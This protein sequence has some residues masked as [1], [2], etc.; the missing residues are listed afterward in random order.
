MK[1]QAQT[2]EMGEQLFAVVF[3]RVVSRTAKGKLKWERGYRAPRVAD[4]NSVDIAAALA[5]KLPEWE[6]LGIVP[7]EDIP[8]GAKTDEPLRYG[9]RKWS[10]LFSGRQL[11]GHGTAVEIYRA[12]VEE[13]RVAGL[14]SEIR[15]AAYV[16]LAF[17][18]DKMLNYNSRMSVWMSTRE[19]VA[20]TFNRHDFAFCWSHAEMAVLVDGLGFDW[21]VEQTSKCI[22]ELVDLCGGGVGPLFDDA[23]TPPLTVTCQSGDDLEHIAAAS[24]D[25]VIID[26][27]YGANVMY[28]ELSDFFYVWLKRT[29]GVVVPE[30]FTRYL[31]DKDAEAVAN[32]S[33]FAGEKGADKL[34]GRHYQDR[35]AAIFAEARRV[36]KA[37]GI[38]TVMFT[39]KDTGAWD[40]LTQGL[41]TAGFRITASWPVNTEAEGSLHIKD[42]AAANSTIFLVCRPRPA[43]ASDAEISY[44]EDVEPLVAK[45]V[46]DRVAEFQ[47]AGIKGVDLALASFGPALEKFSEHWPLRR[48]S[49]RPRPKATS[50]QLALFEDEFDPYAVSPEDA[51][52][53]ARR[54]VVKWRLDQITQLE[55]RADLDPVTVWF[56]LA[57][58]FFESSTFSYDEGL[59]L[60]RAV[61][62][63]LETDIVKRVAE[64]KGSDLR[65]W[66][67]AT[68]AAKG[69]LGPADGSRSWLDA[70]HAAA[71]AA[72]SKSLE[73][74]RTLLDETGAAAE[75]GFLRALE[76]VL[77][78]LPVSASL[79]GRDPLKDLNKAAGDDF[80]ALENLRRLAF[81][82]EVGEPDQLRQLLLDLEPAVPE[83]A[84][85]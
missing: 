60:A 52:Q 65:L 35:M 62:V 31:T 57:W 66:D 81:S 67:S 55:V 16:Y 70:L 39:H 54:E 1:R 71:W 19:V 61:G 32:K 51:L 83:I 47:A 21:A 40:A 33:R 63:D 73:T 72:R 20:N 45:A 80:E 68:R 11:L 10:D 74:A 2:G 69:A 27:P 8:V 30:L 77:E 84:A 46:R 44:W 13:D 79:G 9:A 12:M 24:V 5:A 76:A 28:A 75:P 3:R 58:D 26:P 37:D 82:E 25:A 23:A 48:G 18:L 36:L 56:V 4:N 29:A 22:K 15:K 50:R 85:E 34:A 49:P 78:V 38:M 53:A 43:V 6:A 41:M 17:S 14:L 64:K 7:I 59:R 42:K